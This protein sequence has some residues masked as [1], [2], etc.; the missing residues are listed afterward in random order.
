MA[1][2]VF[3]LPGEVDPKTLAAAKKTARTLDV[4]VVRGAAGS[5]LV[6]ATQTEA[7]RLSKELP[8][9]RYVPERKTT[10]ISK[11]TPPE[12]ARM[13]PVKKRQMPP[14]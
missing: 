4:S 14:T 1:R 12:R 13:T 8:G 11:P 7:T 9:W 2:F 5:M 3:F 10:R 6:E